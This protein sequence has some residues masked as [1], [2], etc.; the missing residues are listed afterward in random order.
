[1]FRRQFAAAPASPPGASPVAIV[2]FDEETYRRPPFAGT[3]SA[4][5]TPELAHV[6]DALRAAGASVIGIDV[7]LPTSGQRA[8]ANFDR[9]WLEA[10]SAAAKEKRIVLGKVQH[11]SHPILPHAA[12]QIAVGGE[13]SIRAVNLASDPD[14][15]VRRVPLLF[16]TVGGGREP[17][18]ALEVA[19]R[20]LG[21]EA[22]P[23]AHG[24]LRIGAHAV[25]GSAESGLLVN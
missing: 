24:R 13:R 8:A 16:T 7:I 17:S 9:P 21:G 19:A 3:P 11:G 6:V 22:A 15:V 5:W 12:Q 2:A 25:P 1:W 23:D 10:L 18:F 14:D 20:A 4:L